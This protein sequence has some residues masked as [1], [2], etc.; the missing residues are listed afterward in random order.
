VEE[1]D[2]RLGVLAAI[3]A[4]AVS[5][6]AHA[7]QSAPQAPQAR[8]GGRVVFVCERTPEASRSFEREHGAPMTFMSADQLAKAQA[9][10]ETWS[11]PRCITA[12]ELQRFESSAD[13]ARMMR[14][15]SN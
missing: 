1:I 10:K 5:A 3:A 9:N 2:M 4:L 15:R 13:G 12:A 11:A 6:Q 7:Q 14:A 8:D